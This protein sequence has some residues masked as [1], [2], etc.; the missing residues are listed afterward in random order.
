MPCDLVTGQEK[1]YASGRSDEPA[2][3]ICCTVEMTNI[4][5]Q[6]ICEF[7]ACINRQPFLF[8]TDDVAVIDEIQMLSDHIRGGA[9]TRAILGVPAHEVHLCGEPRS[10]QL[11]AKLLK[12][13]NEDVEV[14]YLYCG[15]F[16][17]L[18]HCL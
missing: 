3:H 17:I 12:H 18:V 6:Q 5:T 4:T 11:I 7:V 1:R 9:W 2:N 16:L 14:R 13:V 10:A 8:F 15:I